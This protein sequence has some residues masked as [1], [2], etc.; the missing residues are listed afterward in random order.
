MDLREPRTGRAVLAAWFVAVLALSAV[1]DARVLA[2]LGAVAL[3]LFWRGSLG[4][5]RKLLLSVVPVTTLLALGSLGWLRWVEGADPALAPFVALVLRATLIAFA[6]LSV[7]ARVDLLRALAPWPTL[8]RLLV[9]TLAQIHALRLLVTES[10]QGLHSRLP[11]KPGAADVLRNAGGV[12][13]A[14]FTLSTRN[15]REVSDALRSRGF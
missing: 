1:S 3:A 10:R 6:T 7:L 2:A 11:R 8:S 15:A 14:L 13:G 5:L 12:S 9:V 4:V